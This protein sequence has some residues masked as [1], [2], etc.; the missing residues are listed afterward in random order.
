MQGKQA[1]IFANPNGGYDVRIIDENDDVLKEDGNLLRSIIVTEVKMRPKP[2]HATHREK[3]VNENEI[4]DDFRRSIDAALKGLES[5]YH[6]NSK[7]NSE[8]G[9][10]RDVDGATSFAPPYSSSLLNRSIDSVP[11]SSTTINDQRSSPV[12]QRSISNINEQQ[13]NSLSDRS[14]PPV[15]TLNQTNASTHHVTYTEII[16]SESRDGEQTRRVKSESYDEPTQPSSTMKITTKSEFSAD[17][18][19]GEKIMEQSVQVISVKV[20]NEMTTNNV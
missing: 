13:E 1:A 20:H 2:I 18:T 4:G 17:P 5:V 7:S 6:G 14:S 3:L 15:D 19:S 12:Q 16:R 9:N 8:N 10:V 11:L